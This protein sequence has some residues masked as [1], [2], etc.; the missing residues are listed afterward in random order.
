M[1]LRRIADRFP[2]SVLA[3]HDVAQARAVATRLLGLRHGR[4]AFDALPSAVTDAEVEA[5]YAP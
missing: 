3:L 4:V 5:L 2:A 1:L